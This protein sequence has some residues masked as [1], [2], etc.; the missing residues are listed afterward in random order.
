MEILDICDERGL[1]TGATI[2]RAEAHS[3]GILHRRAHVWVVR[4]REGRWEI[5]LQKRAKNKESFPG[6]FDTSSGGHIPS[7]AE[8]LD[9][10]LRELEEEWGIRARPEQLAYVGHFRSQYEA[11][12]YGALFRDNEYT[13]VYV[14]REPVD[15]NTL[16]LQTEEVEEVCWFDLEDVREEIRTRR[17]RICVPSDG[18]A[19]L[20]DYLNR[21]A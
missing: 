14:Y 11:V 16:C 12:F 20:T 9:S 19:V 5:L 17:A 10:A 6:M 8:P 13:R 18:L 4:R 21:E 15:I 7:G 1:P 2:E 3:R